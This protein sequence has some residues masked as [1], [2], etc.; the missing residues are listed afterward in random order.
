MKIMRLLDIVYED[1]MDNIQINKAIKKSESNDYA[2]GT[3]FLV[4]AMQN[5]YKVKSDM[6]IEQ[7]NKEE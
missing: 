3:K 4:N 7:E 1:K 2:D 6:I 5:T